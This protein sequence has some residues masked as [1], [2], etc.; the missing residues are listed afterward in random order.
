VAQGAKPNSAHVVDS[1]LADLKNVKKANGY[2]MDVRHVALPDYQPYQDQMIAADTP[3]LQV[4]VVGDGPGD[5]LIGLPRKTLKVWIIGVI[6][7][8]DRLQQDLLMLADDV[9]SIMIFNPA[10]NFPG[11][12]VANTYGHYT[13]Q[14]EE[15]VSFEVERGDQSSNVGIFL[16]KWRVGYEFPSPHG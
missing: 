10:R 4:W 11:S 13:D 2:W 5:S 9:K 7:Q 8:S 3:S 12:S 16:S 15:G 14:D 6:K 1:I